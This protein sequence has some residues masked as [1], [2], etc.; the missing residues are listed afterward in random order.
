MTQMACLKLSIHAQNCT[1][2]QLKHLF[3]SSKLTLVE[4]ILEPHLPR[5]Q[6]FKPKANGPHSLHQFRNLEIVFCFCLL[7]IFLA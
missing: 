4:L 5:S 6:T 7:Q 3:C 2:C 1:E